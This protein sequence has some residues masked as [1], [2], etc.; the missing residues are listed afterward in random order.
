MLQFQNMRDLNEALKKARADARQDA[1]GP[2]CIFARGTNL[3]TADKQGEQCSPRIEAEC[4]GWN[5]TWKEIKD[6]ITEVETKYPNV[7]EIYLSGGY[8]G[9][10]SPIDYHRHGNYDPWVSSWKVTVW[11]RTDT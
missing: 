7:Q 8:D 6:L 5:N 4:P 10:D 9:A 3:S 1:Q 2:K 11:K